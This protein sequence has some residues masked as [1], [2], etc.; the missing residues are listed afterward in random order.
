MSGRRRVLGHVHFPPQ[1]LRLV[2]AL[3]AAGPL[4]ANQ[5]SAQRSPPS[6]RLVFDSVSSAALR[7]NLLGDRGVRGLIVYLPPGYDGQPQRRYPS[8]YL[9]HGGRM[10]DSAWIGHGGNGY[11]REWPDSTKPLSVA[12]LMDGLLRV[13]LVHPMI[14]VMP[15]ARDAYDASWYA[16]SVIVGRW[17]DYFT[18]D[19][20]AHVDSVYR[21]IPRAASRGIAGHS[22]GAF[23]AIKLAMTHGDRFGALFALSPC[24]VDFT[25]ELAFTDPSWRATLQLAETAGPNRFKFANRYDWAHFTAAAAFSPNVGAA[26]LHVSWP[27]TATEAAL[28]PVDSVARLWTSQT[29][30]ALVRQGAATLRGMK[31]IRLEHGTREPLANLRSGARVLS[32]SLT[33]LGVPHEYAVFEGG[34]EDR[35][36]Q[37][38]RD[39][40]LPFFSS[41]LDRSPLVPPGLK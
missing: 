28:V 3:A 13:G 24:C 31:G 29:P 22:L 5:L 25:E 40:L 37:R 6:G 39:V 36:A 30:V 19:L 27:V 2:V 8:V 11:Y 20:I 12:A 33:T 16:N 26:P 10:S 9:L 21:T 15:D 18:K 35:I 41:V 38:L 34:H 14:I 17:E 7:Q 32:D 4:A 23:G 1:V